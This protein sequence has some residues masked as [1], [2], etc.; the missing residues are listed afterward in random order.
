MTQIPELADCPFV[1]SQVVAWGDMDALGHLN[2]I[3]YYRYS[4]SARIG[5]FLS[6]GL[7]FKDHLSVVAHSSCQY[8]HPVVFP[9]TLSVGVA[10]KKIGTT[11]AIFEHLF[12]SHA[13]GRLVAK[14]E[15]V[16]VSIDKSGH[17]K[18][19]DKA[20]LTAIKSDR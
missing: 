12:Y 11:S 15:C 7:A 10:I 3:V 16:I 2:N 14:G 19:W 5:Y 9:D 17:K 1:F 13:Q 18:A 8:M 4:E 6:L 20:A